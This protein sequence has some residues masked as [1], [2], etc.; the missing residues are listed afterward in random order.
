MSTVATIKDL[1]PTS[2]GIEV[3]AVND[4]TAFRIQ[5]DGTLASLKSGL[6]TVTT[7]HN[8]I[9]TKPEL[10]V[11]QVVDFTPVVPVVIPPTQA[12]KDRAAWLQ[13]Q[14]VFKQCQR[15]LADGQPGFDQ[16]RLDQARVDR[17]KLWN[18]AY[19]AFV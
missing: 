4:G 18:A 2:S 13:A 9:T 10:S 17:D 12:E 1:Q 7:K 8:D 6:Q 11:G 16:A 14:S 5:T 19:E 3:L 15:G